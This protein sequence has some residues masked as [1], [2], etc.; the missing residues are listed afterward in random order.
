MV[1]LVNG[2]ENKAKVEIIS[3]CIKALEDNVV[4][5]DTIGNLTTEFIVEY[6][7]EYQEILK[8]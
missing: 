6:L 4:I 5:S 2:N 7:K 3:G 1:V 8:G